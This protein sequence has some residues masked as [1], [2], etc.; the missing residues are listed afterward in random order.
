M[1]QSVRSADR[2]NP[3]GRY[4]REFRRARTTR[5]I[6]SFSL[7]VSIRTIMAT[8]FIVSVLKG[9]GIRTTHTTRSVRTTRSTP[10]TENTVPFGLSRRNRCKPTDR[11]SRHNP[12]DPLIPRN[13]HSQFIPHDQ[14]ARDNAHN[15]AHRYNRHH[16]FVSLLGGGGF[17]P[18]GPLY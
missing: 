3:Q 4:D 7:S 11:H 14:H 8:S 2:Y 1:L 6:R 16:R 9:G 10:P 18:A 15:Q 17:G 12:V 13:P 5:T